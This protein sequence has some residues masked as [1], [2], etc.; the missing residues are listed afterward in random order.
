MDG[1]AKQIS[2]LAKPELSVHWRPAQS[3]TLRL[4][5][6]QTFDTGFINLR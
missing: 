4:V 6:K 5:L 1:Q 2:G 3:L